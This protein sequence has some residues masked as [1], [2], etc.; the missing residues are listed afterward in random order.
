MGISL[1]KK[2]RKHRKRHLKSAKGRSSKKQ[3]KETRNRGDHRVQIT[4][5]SP[6]TILSQPIEAKCQSVSAMP[7]ASN[8]P[9]PSSIIRDVLS[10]IKDQQL[11]PSTVNGPSRHTSV[12]SSVDTALKEPVKLTKVY[13]SDR[14]SGILKEMG[15]EF[16]CAPP[17]T[18]TPGNLAISLS[19]LW[20]TS[21][22]YQYLLSEW[23]FDYS[24][25]W[26]AE[27]VDFMVF[28]F[29]KILFNTEN[30]LSTCAKW[31]IGNDWHSSALAL[32][33]RSIKEG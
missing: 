13:L 26:H 27:P 28:N 8:P 31:K 19:Y 29:P 9:K 15:F 2:E 25:Q 22:Q 6:N 24:V 10:L 30:L 16:P 21:V 32:K 20:V 11:P 23:M 1:K 12:N 18:P 14:Q 7:K 33:Y 5:S 4:D 17:A 3:T